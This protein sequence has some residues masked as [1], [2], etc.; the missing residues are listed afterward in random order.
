MVERLNEQDCRQGDN[1][2][3]AQQ[4]QILADRATPEQHKGV[5]R[6]DHRG[7]TNPEAE[8]YACILDE[9]DCQTFKWYARFEA[10]DYAIPTS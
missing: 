10:L 1:F 4:L 6:L 8:R 7:K 3:I 5:V 2:D 9:M